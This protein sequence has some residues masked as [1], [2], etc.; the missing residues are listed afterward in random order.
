MRITHIAIDNFKILKKISSPASRFVCLI[1][2]N[3]SGKS[4]LLQA[5]LLFIEARKIQSDAFY[6][7]T[8]AAT[9]SVR[10]SELSD[11]DL[12]LI[13]NTEHRDRIK[14][15]LDNGSLTLV[16]R[17]ETDGTTRLRWITRLPLD[18]RFEQSAI[19]DLL[20]GKRPGSSLVSEVTGIFPEFKDRI[21][22]KTNQS[23]VRDLIEELVRQI[24]DTEKTDRECDL[25]SGMDNT[26]RPLLPEPIYIPAVKDLADDVKTKDSTSF[27][28]LLGILLSQITPQLKSAEETFK[29]LNEQLNRIEQS[30][31]TILDNRL[32]AV[33]TIESMIETYVKENFRAVTLNINIPPPEIKTVLSSAQIFANDGVRG[34]L[35][36]KGD[37]LKRAVTF[38]ILRA[39]VELKRKQDALGSKSTTSP[40]YLFLFE[41]PELYLHPT[42][43]RI[44]FD[45]LAEIAKTHHVIV[46][47]H[48]PL[49][50]GPESTGTFV[51]LGRKTDAKYGPKPF[52]E[53]FP[54]DLS[55]INQKTRF[56]LITYETSNTAF[57]CE[58]VVLVEGDSDFLVLPHLA[59]TLNPSW[60]PNRVGLAFC[61]ISGK[62]SIARYREFFENFRIRVCVIGD[63]DCLLDGFHHLEA[64]GECTVMRDKLLEAVDDYAANHT[65]TGKLS[66]KDLKEIAESVTR[67]DQFGVICETYRACLEGRATPDD[68]RG[69]G[70]AFFGDETNKKRRAVLQDARDEAIVKA[71]REL[72]RSLRPQ[73]IFILDRGDIEAYYPNQIEG[74]DKPSKALDFCRRISTRE[75]ALALC[76]R[77]PTDAGTGEQAEFEVIFSRIFREGS[78][79]A[80]PNPQ[81]A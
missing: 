59:R 39:Y 69:A 22:S 3:N 18:K 36:S 38:A 44:L 34:E 77:I 75:E 52:A 28:K 19:D 51:K 78:V 41:E 13:S 37:G 54:I 8:Q 62:G 7:P 23:Q 47:T 64:Q 14:A 29:I 15:I 79:E 30:D 20:K 32:E 70:D 55:S 66:S 45:A 60:E 65:I 10:L 80:S 68:L 4:S 26:V 73:D 49:F 71:K 9:V 61:R 57:F 72:I 6:D 76:D 58:T 16:R 24:P 48:S 21:D 12:A 67:R 5:L 35:N 33:K 46:S 2:E 1:G 56:Q 74:T 25:P 81:A 11:D 63:L 27:G 31:G 53:A 42:A 40:G 43:Q 50:F 17:F